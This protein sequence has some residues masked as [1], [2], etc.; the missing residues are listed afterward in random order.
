MDINYKD[1]KHAFKNFFIREERYKK[2][3]KNSQN[4]IYFYS[5]TN[6]I[7][8]IKLSNIK[9]EPGTTDFFL[10]KLLLKMKI[11]EH[12]KPK[13]LNL[14]VNAELANNFVK[15]DNGNIEIVGSFDFVKTTLRDFFPKITNLTMEKSTSFFNQQNMVKNQEENEDI[16]ELDLEKITKSVS[17]L[18]AR[19]S[20][21]KLIFT[22]F[23]LAA[24]VLTPI[25]WLSLSIMYNLNNYTLDGIFG[26]HS[27]FSGGTTLSLTIDGGQWWRIFT[28]GFA[29][30]TSQMFSNIFVIGFGGI[31]LYTALKFSEATIKAWKLLLVMLMAYIMTGLFVS[32]MFPMQ[33][34]AGISN[35]TAIA[36]GTLIMSVAADSKVTSK[37]IKLKMIWPVLILILITMMSG[38]GKEDFI[39][40]GVGLASGSALMALMPLKIEQSMIT[41]I[42]ALVILLALIIVPII[43]IFIR[44]FTPATDIRVLDTLEAYIRNGLMSKKTAA[45]IVARIGWVYYFPGNL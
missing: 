26:V 19:T 9:L 45:D 16:G 23:V 15:D 24:A 17:S 39:A 40:M 2:I 30:P 35:I 44:E 41:K 1:I 37:F 34:T 20:P 12:H 3:T 10:E 18:I 8:V 31:A 42:G 29:L 14:I 33:I 36:V 5:S 27:L 4:A 25:V 6:D 38:G 22:W 28:Y 13:F 21:N 7:N 11:S 43:F 32:V